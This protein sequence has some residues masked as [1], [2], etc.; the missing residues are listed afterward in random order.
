MPL[1]LAADQLEADGSPGGTFAPIG[2]DSLAGCLVAAWCERTTNSIIP[3]RHDLSKAIWCS[4]HTGPPR[5]RLN[6]VPRPPAPA[7]FQ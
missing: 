7:P 2:E 6:T 3:Q 5:T 4:P 1:E